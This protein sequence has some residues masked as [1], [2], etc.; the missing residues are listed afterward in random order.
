MA[1]I[2]RDLLQDLYSGVIAFLHFSSER[3]KPRVAD[4]SRRFHIIFYPTAMSVMPPALY[5]HDL[6]YQGVNEDYC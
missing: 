6:P 1:E 3:A 2:D 5:L 4:K